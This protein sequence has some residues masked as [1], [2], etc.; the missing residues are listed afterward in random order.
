[1]RAREREGVGFFFKKKEAMC[2]KIKIK[3]IIIMKKS[4]GERCQ[5]E[6]ESSKQTKGCHMPCPRCAAPLMGAQSPLGGSAVPRR[7]TGS[8]GGTGTGTG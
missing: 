4:E 6:E 3:K 5:A 2:G 7:S 8:G 1:M